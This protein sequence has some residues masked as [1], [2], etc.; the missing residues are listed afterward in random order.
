M[1]RQLLKRGAAAGAAVV[2]LQAAYAV[3]K[4]A[5]E[6]EQFDPS[7]EFG[8]PSHPSLRVVVLGDS[9]VTA[10]GVAGPDEIWVSIICQRLAEN[11]HVLLKS[12]AVGGSMAHNLISEQMEE[13]ILFEPDLILLSVGANDVIKGV[14]RRVFTRNLDILVGRLSE[15]D[16]V[17]VQSGVGVLGTIPRLYPPL[18]QMVSRRARRFDEVHWEIA[19]RYGTTV[20]DQRS[21][22]PRVWSSDAGLWA[23]DEFHVSASGHARWAETAWQTIG[24]LMNGSGE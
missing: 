22:D 23:A 19:D 17:V 3:L 20:V 18:S 1:V 24:P 15:T 10:P 14:P 4:P 7:G 13:A 5:P 9:S 2:S 8:D 12:V 6:L 21:D 16:A 11:R